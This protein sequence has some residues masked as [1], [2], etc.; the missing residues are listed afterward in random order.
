MAATVGDFYERVSRA[1]R[2]GTVYDDDIPGYAADAVR[3]LEDMENWKYMSQ[4]PAAAA[5]TIGDNTITLT[6]CKSVRWLHIIDTNNEEIPLTKTAR[7]DVQNISSG[8]PGA[9]WMINRNQIGL[10]ALPDQAY[11]YKIGYFQYSA[12]P[13]VDSLEWLTMAEDLLIART[14]RKMQPLLRDD[15]LVARWKEIEDS[16]MP[17]LLESELVSEYDG[18]VNRMVPFTE[19]VQED[20]LDDTDF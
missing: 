10:D 15:K 11:N 6:R 13:L 1:I 12:I 4:E 7:D 9:F 5:L 17:S 8:R 14:I 19:E 3:E 16:R 2:R 20:L 18:Q